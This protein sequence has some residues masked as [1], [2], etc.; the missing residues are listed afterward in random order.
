VDADEHR[1]DIDGISAHPRD[2]AIIIGGSNSEHDSIIAL[3]L[4]DASKLS[5]RKSFRLEMRRGAAK[6]TFSLHRK[7]EILQDR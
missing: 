3:V 1:R 7:T 4:A 5:K 6:I 2:W